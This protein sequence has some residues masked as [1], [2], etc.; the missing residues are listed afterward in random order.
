M[1]ISGVDILHRCVSEHS[2]RQALQLRRPR[3][4]FPNLYAKPRCNDLLSAID[5]TLPAVF[6]RHPKRV[7]S[8]ANKRRPAYS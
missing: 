1:E 7:G 2:G 5:H 8:Y 3:I 6:Q 4:A